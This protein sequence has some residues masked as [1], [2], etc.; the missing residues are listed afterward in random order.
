MAGVCDSVVDAGGVHEH[1]V[2]STPPVPGTAVAFR[3]RGCDHGGV[4]AGLYGGAVFTLVARVASVPTT[5]SS[6]QR[7]ATGT[8]RQHVVCELCYEL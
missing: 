2:L 5:T 8:R 7:L 6:L 4:A 3:Y 1:S